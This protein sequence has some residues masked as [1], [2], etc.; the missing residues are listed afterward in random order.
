MQKAKNRKGFTLIELIVVM[1]I[2]GVLV[3]LAAPKFL[4][5]TKDANVATMKAD[6]RVLANSALVYNIE[7]DNSWPVGDPAEAATVPTELQ[8]KLD[9]VAG[10]AVVVNKIDEN[11]VGEHIQSLKGNVS[12]YGIVI[13]KGKLQGEVIHLKGVEDRKGIT[14]FGLNLTK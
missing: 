9:T 7:H 2:L 10:E 1:A 6:A 4:G 12:D 14:H 5:Y 11:K 13:T 3:L 8:T